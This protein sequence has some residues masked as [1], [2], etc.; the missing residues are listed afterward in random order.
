MMHKDKFAAVGGP[1]GMPL[2]AI[3]GM[4]PCTELDEEV[5]CP[6]CL[7]IMVEEV[8]AALVVDQELKQQLESLMEAFDGVKESFDKHVNVTGVGPS[9][10]PMPVIIIEGIVSTK[11]KLT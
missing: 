9:G 3:V 11:V 4:L 10:P 5:T 6:A 7:D 1:L 8:E 2:C